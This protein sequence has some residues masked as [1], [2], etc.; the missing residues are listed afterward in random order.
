MRSFLLDEGGTGNQRPIASFT[1]SCTDLTCEFTDTS[2]DP[3]GTITAW[4][5]NFGDGNSSP[6]QHPI[7]TYATAG[8]YYVTLM[9]TDDGGLD[10]GDTQPVTVGSVGPAT[11]ILSELLYDIDGIDDGLEWV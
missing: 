11:V 2:T 5:W 6:E 1:F 3:D 7:H 8:T 9:V 10:D 4:S